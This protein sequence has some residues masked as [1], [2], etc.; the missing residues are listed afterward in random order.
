MPEDSNGTVVMD[1]QNLP[2]IEFCVPTRVC[3]EPGCVRHL[4]AVLHRLNANRVVFV[5][6]AGLGGSAIVADA[7]ASLHAAG[8]ETEV[9]ADVETNPRTTTAERVAEVARDAQ[10]IVGFGGGSV[11]DAAKGAAMLAIV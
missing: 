10:A 5:T 3:I 1:H 8:I 7:L 4:A 11:M 6:D 9:I 2:N